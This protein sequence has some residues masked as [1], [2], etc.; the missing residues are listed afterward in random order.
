MRAIGQGLRIL[1]ILVV[2]IGIAG[3]G[4]RYYAS[5]SIWGPGPATA[6]A[7]VVIAKGSRTETI[8]RQLQ[9][10]GVVS[11][12]WI[13][14]AAV[15]LLDTGGPLDAG[16]YAFAPS[17]TLHDVLRQI[18]E[19]RTVVHRLTAPEGLSI[20][21]ILALVIAE[22]ALSGTV[23][24]VPPEG[25]LMPDTY[26]FSLGDSRSDMIARM[27]RA[28]DK[29]LGEAW[30]KR[31]PGTALP[32]PEAVLTLASIVEKE[33]A[34]PDERPKVAA[35]FLNRLARGMKLQADPTV[36]YGLTHGKAPLGRPLGHAD[37]AIDSPYNSYRYDGLPPTPIAC[38]GRGSI[39]A[40]LHPDST[41]ALYFVADGS[42]RHAFAES[43]DEHNRNVTKLRQ[44]EQTAAPAEAK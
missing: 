37:L 38:P 16:E 27:R 12:W 36:I 18:R 35:V 17:Q 23:T 5:R 14:E 24:A 30:A 43:L 34:I 20:A 13:F 25:S 42:G 4:V 7:T 28:M 2:V 32:S 19:G 3:V 41:G 22:P 1:I 6:P 33:S 40:V 26:N 31:S 39:N 11:H 44:L 21:E 29:A 8:G 9:D 15:Q 10:A